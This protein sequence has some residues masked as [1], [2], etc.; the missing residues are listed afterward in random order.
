MLQQDGR[1]ATH[2]LQEYSIISAVSDLEWNE[3]STVE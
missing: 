1:V 2:D 3:Y